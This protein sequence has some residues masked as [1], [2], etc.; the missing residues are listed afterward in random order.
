[1][2]T[3]LNTYKN[4]IIATVIVMLIIGLYFYIHGLKSQIDSLRSDLK[5]SQ[6]ELAN[7][8]L[9]ST[10][11]KSA[12]DIQNKAVEALKSNMKVQMAKLDKWKTQPPKI[13]YKTITKIKEVKSNEC[14]DIKT[15][16]DA[17]RHIDYNS[18]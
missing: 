14:K 18:L 11:Y 10:R 6:I 13:K 4:M 16:L 5:D 7:S 9:E 3:L 2:F 15:Q 12:L 17:V 1:M 8:K